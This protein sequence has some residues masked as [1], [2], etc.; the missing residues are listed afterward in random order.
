MISGLKFQ[1]LLKGLDTTRDKISC[2]ISCNIFHTC[3]HPC[4]SCA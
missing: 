4:N 1:N 2:N 3:I